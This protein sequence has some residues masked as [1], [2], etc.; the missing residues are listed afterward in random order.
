MR[1]SPEEKEHIRMQRMVTSRFV[2]NKNKKENGKNRNVRWK[3]GKKGARARDPGVRPL[4]FLQFSSSLFSH[5][6]RSCHNFHSS[7]KYNPYPRALVGVFPF[8]LKE[9]LDCL[10]T[11]PSPLLPFVGP[12]SRTGTSLAAPEPGS[13][14]IF[15]ELFPAP[16]SAA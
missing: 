12:E 11:F 8:R 1:E 7:S 15:K 4:L 3:R 9:L 5:C 10:G 13:R 6:S 14:S 16:C 2:G